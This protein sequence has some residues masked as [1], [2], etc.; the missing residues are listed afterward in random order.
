VRAVVGAV[1][2]YPG[3][4]RGCAQSFAGAALLSLR[5]L[6][7]HFSELAEPQKLIKCIIQ[8]VVSRPHPG[9]IAVY[10]QATMRVFGH[11][12]AEIAEQWGDSDLPEVK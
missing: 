10:S 12:A 8:P 6:P 7:M 1:Q 11:W 4:L 3:P 9:A 2:R 5:I